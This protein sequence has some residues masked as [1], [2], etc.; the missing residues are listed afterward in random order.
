VP[1]KYGR[2]GAII[3]STNIDRY[4]LVTI[5]LL[6]ICLITGGVFLAVKLAG[7]RPQE[8]ILTS[9]KTPH[10]ITEIYIDGTVMNPGYY[11]LRESDSI[12][13]LIQCAG[14]EPEAKLQSI[15]LSI[16]TNENDSGPQR[17]SLNRADVWLLEALP[18]IGSEKA[19]AI[20][21]Y[22][23]EHGYFDR[24]EDLL[25]VNGIGRTTFENIR[26]FITVED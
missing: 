24:I 21:D 22:R 6:M 26:D 7:H 25:Q 17:I 2:R 10:E 5:A 12:D 16:S 9:D 4:W 11:P 3:M 8:I 19:Q 18:G 13:S 1:Q 20:V 14:I 23:N 15:K